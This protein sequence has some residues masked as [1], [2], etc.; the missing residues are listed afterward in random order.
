[1]SKSES[2]TFHK[3]YQVRAYTSRDG[4]ARCDEVLELTR[5]LYNAA[6]Q[7]R[8]LAFRSPGRHSLTIYHQSKE[9][10]DV[11]AHDSRHA[12]LSRRIQ[13]GALRRLDKAYKAFFQRIQQNGKGGFPRYKPRQRW[14]TIDLWGVEPSWIKPHPTGPKV[15]IAIKGLPRLTLKPRF[16]LPDPQQLVNVSLSRRGRRILANLT[17]AVEIPK[18]PRRD[19][20]VGLHFGIARRIMSSAGDDIT[21]VKI[22]KAHERRKHRLQRRMERQRAQA[23][24]DGR[25]THRQAGWRKDARTGAVAPR[26]ALHWDKFSRSYGKTREALAQL[27]YRR[28]VRNKNAVHQV[29]TEIVK[30]AR[31]YCRSRIRHLADG[32]IREWHT[33]PARRGRGE[34]EEVK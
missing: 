14:R 16:E 25:A 12:A 11:R 21:P 17:Y 1:M 7:Q 18:A 3:T 13:T 19:E 26:F 24:K 22:D 32:R 6:R 28:S 2:R 31:L 15:D 34:K 30:T 10:T 23:L 27:D 29:T 9:L 5:E 20:R 8:V 4:Y 33:R